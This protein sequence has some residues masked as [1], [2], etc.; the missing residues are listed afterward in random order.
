MPDNKFK[1]IFERSLSEQLDLIK[2]QIKQ[3]QSENI[4]HGLYNIYRDGRYKHNGVLIRRYSDRRVV[5]R[6]DSV[7]GTTQTIKTSK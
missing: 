3:V 7:T 4:S 1:P 5:V 6:V 2:P